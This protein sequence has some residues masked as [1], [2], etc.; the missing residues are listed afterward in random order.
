MMERTSSTLNAADLPVAVGT[1]SAIV[2]KSLS[3]PDK[4][5]SAGLVERLWHIGPMLVRLPLSSD[6]APFII[7]K[8]HIN[9]RK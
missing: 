6:F 9:K 3:L 8:Q 5:V 1:D 2:I 4:S 7:A